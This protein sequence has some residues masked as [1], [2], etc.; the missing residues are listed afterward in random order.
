MP[1]VTQL[2]VKME[3]KPGTLAQLCSELAKVAVN[4]SGIMATTTEESGSVRI[5]ATPLP[6]A[7]KVLDTLKMSYEEQPAVAVHV[8]DRPGALGRVT[9]KLA[10]AGINIHYTYGSIVRDADRA[11]IVLGVSDPDKAAK[12]L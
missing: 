6:A 3:N 8:T 1:R 7:K 11:L 9:R 12:L 10:D 2:M 5:L 4:I